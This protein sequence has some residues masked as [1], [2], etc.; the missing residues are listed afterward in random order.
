[1]VLIEVLELIVHVDRC[2][3]VFL[4]EHSELT[5]CR[6]WTS[7]YSVVLARLNLLDLVTHDVQD[8]TQTEEN[9]SKDSEDDHG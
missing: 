6:R 3:D 2:L 7:A 5:E 9:D 1:V 4:D 8:D